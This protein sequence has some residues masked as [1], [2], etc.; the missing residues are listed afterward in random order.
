MK[1]DAREYIKANP[2]LGVTTPAQLGLK[3]KRQFRVTPKSTCTTCH[4]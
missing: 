3:L 4:Q 1:Y 2:Q